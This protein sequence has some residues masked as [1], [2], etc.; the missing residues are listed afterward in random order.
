MTKMLSAAVA[1]VAA[2]ALTPAAF[3]ANCTDCEPGGGGGGGTPN[4]LPTAA[5][6]IS[7]ANVN[8][9]ENVSFTNTSTDSDGS[10]ASSSWNFGDGAT[11]T[12]TS[13]SHSYANGGTYTV[14]LQVTDNNGGTNSITHQVVVHDQA[15]T[16]DFTYAPT[17]PQLGE[18][19]QFT[20]IPYD[21]EGHVSSVYW[22]FG[23]GRHAD[24]VS[25][26]ISFDTPGDHTVTF[27][28]FDAQG[29]WQGTPHVVHVNV[30]PTVAIQVGSVNA[31]T[32]SL[33]AD[34]NDPDG[35]I[36]GYSWD[37]GDGAHSS[38]ANVSHTYAAPGTYT[39]K[40]K[41]I[42][43]RFTQSSDE[44]V[45]NVTAP[46][47]D[48]GGGDTGDGSGST[49]GGGTNTGGGSASNGGGSDT[50]GGSQTGSSGGEVAHAGGKDTSAPALVVPAKLKAK[51]KAGK[52]VY[53]VS[54]NEAATVVAKLKGKVAGTAK[55]KIAKAG[56][57][58]VT[59]KLSTKAKKALRAARS[60]KLAL[61]TTATDAAG[62]TTTKTTKVTLV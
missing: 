18:A 15:P 47:A 49:T 31:L 41:V 50:G 30:P 8:T 34:A 12:A 11:S 19:I 37:F 27:W 1:L 40:V 36:E 44:I 61:V 59:I 25:P 7:D 60:V 38:A 45:V 26:Q 6:T 16:A 28:V 58:K 9:F 39:V 52:L 22:D 13:P 32:V 48:N 21:P 17:I 29:Q 42:D 14:T 5:F 4:V 62:N 20:G 24:V 3:A 51:K 56:K 23:D 55:V 10:I 33:T 35:T 54:T 53:T 2:L 57:G 43:N 46:P